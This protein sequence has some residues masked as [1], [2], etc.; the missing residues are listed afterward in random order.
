VKREDEKLRRLENEKGR[1]KE[2][3]ANTLR[4]KGKNLKALCSS[5]LCG[6]NNKNDPRRHPDEIP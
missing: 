4:R 5:Y 6:S 2:F 1:R 3:H